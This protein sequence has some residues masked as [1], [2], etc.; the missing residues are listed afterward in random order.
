MLFFYKNEDYIFVCCY[1]LLNFF[2][3]NLVKYYG[4]EN[5]Y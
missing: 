4:Y 5:L 1:V 2:I 3:T